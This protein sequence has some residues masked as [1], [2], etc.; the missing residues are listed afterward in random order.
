MFFHLT[1]RDRAL[2]LL[3]SCS[4]LVISSAIPAGHRSENVQQEPMSPRAAV[5]GDFD[6]ELSAGLFWPDALEWNVNALF[7]EDDRRALANKMRTL[8]VVSLEQGCGSMKNRLATLEDG[9]PVCCRYR[10]GGKQLRGDVYSYHFNRL[11][12]MWN[13]PPTVAVKL[14]LSSKQWRNVRANA[15][16]A[17]WKSGFSIVISQF[18]NELQDEHFP[19]SLRNRSS[20]FPLTATSLLNL[21]IPDVK[22]LMEWTDMIVFDF[23]IGHND[24]LFNALLNSKWNSHMMERA[25]H[26]LKKTKY[27]DLVFL[28]NESGF[29]FGYDVAEKEEEYFKLQISFLERICVFRSSTIRALSKLGSVGNTPPSAVLERYIRHVDPSSYSA[30]SVWRTRSQK[31]FDQR[32]RKTLERVHEC[33]LL[34]SR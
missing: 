24:R 13:I 3:L 5:R 15:T 17:G 7:T 10:D 25:V 16:Q 14:D 6:G 21:S 11:L 32:V 1:S 26:N 8:S 18:V 20:L 29:E 34:V 31:E 12:G 9:T 22:Q 4:L 28:D 23:I 33:T 19:S 2:S 27:S 30:L